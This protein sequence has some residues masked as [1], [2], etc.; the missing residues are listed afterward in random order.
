MVDFSWSA[1]WWRAVRGEVLGP[2]DLWDV[3]P[4]LQRQLL[5]LEQA[6]ECGALDGVTFEQM[7]LS[8][9]IPAY[10]HVQLSRHPPDTLVTAG[11]VRA[12]CADVRFHVLS[13]E[14]VQQ[15]EHFR[16][17]F[18]A[19]FELSALYPFGANELCVLLQGKP[20][21]W[22]VP[23]LQSALTFDHGYSS[24]SLQA[25]WL[26]H[27]LSTY[28]PAEQRDFLKFVTG[29][30]RLPVGG[31]RNLKPKLTVVRKTS[32]GDQQAATIL[33]SVMTCTNY[34]KLPEYPS[35]E[36]M[37]DRLHFAITEGQGCFHLS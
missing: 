23:L 31:L 27:I 33:P 4:Q 26:I 20:E 28:S 7:E 19:V 29:S 18:A 14:I 3:D 32:E 34:L 36:C 11:N 16:R 10:P 21:A 15:L 13:T 17:G 25:H 5:R 2:E 37:Q 22:T 35:L 9:Q 30:P 1:A 8:Y 24:D 6:A 12:Y